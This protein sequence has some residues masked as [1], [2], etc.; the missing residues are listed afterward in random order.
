[1]KPDKIVFKKELEEFNILCELYGI[2]FIDIEGSVLPKKPLSELARIIN[3][4]L[5]E[6]QNILRKYSLLDDDNKISEEECLL[7]TFLPLATSVG[8][9]I[10][11]SCVVLS[12]V[13]VL[14]EGKKIQGDFKSEDYEPEEIYGN[15]EFIIDLVK[16]SKLES[17]MAKC[18][19]SKPMT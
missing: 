19:N 13:F 9:S 11:Y 1:M 7:E 10:R 15:T 17:F 12:N 5:P 18:I 6:L 14:K 8:D 4:K 3:L 16:Q 2:E